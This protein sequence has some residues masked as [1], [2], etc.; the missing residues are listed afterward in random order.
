MLYEGEQDSRSCPSLA[1]C[2][3]LYQLGRFI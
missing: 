1:H 2:I 3:T